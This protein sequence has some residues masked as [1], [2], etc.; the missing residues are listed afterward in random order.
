MYPLD[1]EEFVLAN[2][3]REELIAAARKSWEERRPLDRLYHERLSKLFRLYLVVG[4]MPAAVQSSPSGWSLRSA[5]F[6]SRG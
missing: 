3:E 1:F 2:G 5:L 6:N 4:G